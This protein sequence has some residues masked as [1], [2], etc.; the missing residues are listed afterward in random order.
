LPILIAIVIFFVVA[1]VMYRRSGG[2]TR[3]C[4]WR[5]DA[6]GNRG[7]LRKYNC[8]ACGAEAFTS[9]NGPPNDC[10]SKHKPPSL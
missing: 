4:R 8:V 9:T 1:A 2:A 6:N 3:R 10:K 5:A 7:T